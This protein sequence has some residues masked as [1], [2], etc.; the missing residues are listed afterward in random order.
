MV[1]CGIYGL[2]FPH[3]Y[4]KMTKNDILKMD[5]DNCIIDIKDIPLI[6]DEKISTH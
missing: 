1:F 3:I 5:T 4:D 6:L 2:L